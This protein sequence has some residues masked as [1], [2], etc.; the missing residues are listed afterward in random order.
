MS[1]YNEI[2]IAE[3]LKVTVNSYMS[4]EELLTILEKINFKAVESCNI[5]L[6]TDFIYDESNDKIETRTKNININ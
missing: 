6:I 1:G 4:K 2:D 3:N 5:D